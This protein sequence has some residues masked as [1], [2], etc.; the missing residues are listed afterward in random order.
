MDGSDLF[1]RQLTG[2]NSALKAQRL[3]PRHLFGRSVICLGRGMKSQ[4]RPSGYLVQDTHILNEQ[5]I[6]TGRFEFRN[7]PHGVG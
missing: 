7:Q 2:Q 6:D 5:R 4:P 3:Q 1:G